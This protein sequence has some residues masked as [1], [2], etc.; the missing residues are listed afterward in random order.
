L[1]AKSILE[2]PIYVRTQAESGTTG[3]LQWWGLI[4][5]DDYRQERKWAV[6]EMD[7]L[8]IVSG[9][10]GAA[11]QRQRSDQ[12]L[13]EREALYRRAISAAGAVPYYHDHEREEYTFIGDG[14][15]ELTGYSAA[16]ISPAM[17]STLLRDRIF[18]GEAAG[19]DPEQA[20]RMARSG[21]LGVWSCDYLVRTRD[22][23]LRWVADTAVEIPGE[24][25]RP[26]GSVG[27]LQDITERVRSEEEIRE[28]NAALETRVRE[29][30]AELE[31]AN[32]ELEAFAYSVSHDL[33]APLRAIDGYSRMLIEDYADRLDGDGQ[34]FIHNVRQA[35]QNMAY[36]IEDL[37]QLSRVARAEIKRSHVDLSALGR[38]I[39]AEHARQQPD[40]NVTV[41]V[42]PGMA[43]HGDPNLLRVAME[44]LLDNAWKFTA[45]N[46][47]ARIVAGFVQQ[48]GERIYYVQDNGAGFDMRYAHKLFHPFQRLHDVTDFQGTG[49]GLATVER[50]IRR[51]GGR[52]WA[53]AA[54]GQGAA[55]Y[56]TFEPRSSDPA[57]RR[58]K[59][60]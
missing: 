58:A 31:A 23:R 42:L 39:L 6:A 25:G 27:I 53:E 36:L 52:I 55:F 44:N 16:E 54:V 57:N 33:R 18:R 48:D 32:R 3:K 4:G 17:W 8:Q 20:V 47:A 26:T 7:A 2:M 22:G 10:L 28:L 56:F 40:R 12:A 49:V 21:E 24:N 37:L 43:V 13:V 50:I 5:F 30:T 59:P 11:I 15:Q 38:A 9:L 34:T 45:R 35:T 14:I 60:G 19:L 1:G 29:R 46:P 41:E 51:H